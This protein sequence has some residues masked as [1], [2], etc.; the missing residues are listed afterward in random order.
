MTEK[1]NAAR[2]VYTETNK[3]PILGDFDVIIVG[4]GPAGVAAALS[5]AR[6]HL[7][8]LL[9]ESY[10]FLGG[11]WTAG[12]VNPMFD[13]ENKGGICAE[14]V[15]AIN[16]KDM[17]IQMGP[18][19]WCFDTETMKSLLDDLVLSEGITMLLHTHF[20]RPIVLG[21]TIQ[22]V[23]VENKGGCAA[24]KA[25]IVIDCTGDGDVAARAGAPYEIGDENGK[26]QPMTLMFRMSNIDYIQ[27]YYSYPHYKDNELILMIDRALQR[28]GVHDYSFNYRRPCVIPV[29]GA[30]TALCQA[31][32]IRNRLSVDP[33]DLTMAEI[34]GRKEVKRFM[35]LLRQYLP[36]FSRAYLDTTGP[37]IGIRE[38]RRIRGEYRLTEDDIVHSRKFDDGICTATFW[39]DIHQHDDID[40]EEQKDTMLRPDY[41]IPYRCLVPLGVNNLLVAGRCISGSFI[42]HASYRVT[43]NCVA[44]GQAA[45]TAAALCLGQGIAPR[46]LNGVEVANAMVEDG[47]RLA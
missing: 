12:L 37:H 10:G 42:A 26:T 3:I 33:V 8:V 21:D 11:M 40:Q 24:Y 18:N 25:K 14:L 19:M 39:V 29:P 34:E 46:A 30:H 47:A 7:L 38:S 43:G 22:G 6:R 41:Q 45:G 13:C 27:D 32:H 5:A 31:T 36:Q 2:S 28:A 1:T 17:S 9:V 15:D 44:M 4:G 16:R 35:D 20:V 23:I